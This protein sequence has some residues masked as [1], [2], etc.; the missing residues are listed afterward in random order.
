M[1]VKAKNY[2]YNVNIIDI[3]EVD[4][5]NLYNKKVALHDL[6]YFVEHFFDLKGAN[7]VAATIRTE[8]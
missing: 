7:I 1:R 2:G 4:E 5:T 8:E 3:S 6:D